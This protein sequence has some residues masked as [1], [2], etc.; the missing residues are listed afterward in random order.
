MVRGAGYHALHEGINSDHVMLWSDFDFE[1]CF[2][3]SQ[4]MPRSPQAHEFSYDDLQ[5]RE[6]VLSELRRI[7][8]HQNLPL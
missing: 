6:K 7:H 2:G 5:V 8:K 1:E 4:A 3:G